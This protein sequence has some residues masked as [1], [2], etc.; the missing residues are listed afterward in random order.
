MG[1]LAVFDFYGDNPPVTFDDPQPK[2]MGRVYT[3]E[4]FQAM[5]I[6]ALVN[7]TRIGNGRYFSSSELIEI[8]DLLDEYLSDG[9]VNGLRTQGFTHEQ[10]ADI[11]RVFRAYG[12]KGYQLGT[13]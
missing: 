1:L 8:A 6:M 3:G 4:S 11:A 10:I 7:S 2:I 12:E 5:S 9:T 13:I